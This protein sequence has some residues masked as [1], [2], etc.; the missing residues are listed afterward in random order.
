[1]NLDPG[2]AGTLVV[3][4]ERGGADRIAVSD[5]TRF[6]FRTP[7]RAL[8]EVT[9]IGT[10]FDFLPNLKRGFKVHVDVDP[11]LAPTALVAKSVD[12]Q[13]ARFDGE[14][15]VS[16]A[17]TSFTA[18]RHFATPADDYAMTLDYLSNV[19]T[20]GVDANG[21]V[22]HGFKW[23]DLAFPTQVDSGASA[24]ADFEAAIGGAVNFGGHFAGAVRPWGVSFASWNDPADPSGWS[25]SSSI[26]VPT[27]F[28]WS[29][30]TLS[31]AYSA[32][33]CAVAGVSPCVGTFGVKA[34]YPVAGVLVPDPSGS[35]VRVD[36]GG[37]TGSAALV[38][39]V[40]T[41]GTWPNA[42]VTVTPVD[43]ATAAG[44]TALE[45]ALVSPAHVRV[46]GV[47]QPGGHVRAYVVL[48]FTTS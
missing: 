7:E 22:I 14:L 5:T 2:V 17:G 3:S 41:S 23:W 46:F 6:Y 31:G 37:V 48:F 32:A 11:D 43:P 13:I 9:P 45:A 10:G 28:P 44:Q 19:T 47:P 24:I 40:N 26:L 15:A 4:N 27:R 29:Q 1:V 34:L 25:A 8:A 30:V 42:T 12:V 21:D 33:G 39:H 36:V 35:E 16:V 38:W 20:N 18:T